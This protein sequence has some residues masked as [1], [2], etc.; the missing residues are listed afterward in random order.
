MEVGNAKGDKSAKDMD[1][2]IRQ[3]PCIYVQISTY[4]ACG[5]GF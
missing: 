5:A 2:K 4:I 3:Q 1:A